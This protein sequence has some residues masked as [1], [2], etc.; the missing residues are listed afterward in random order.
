M[1]SNFTATPGFLSRFF[2]KSVEE[3]SIIKHFQ[4]VTLVGLQVDYK[5]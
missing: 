3:K 5:F 2:D 1:T 4:K